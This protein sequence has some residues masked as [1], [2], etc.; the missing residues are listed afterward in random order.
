MSLETIQS[1][2]NKTYAD[3][4][5]FI[6]NMPSALNNLAK[7]H[8]LENIR[9]GIN[10]E[11]IKWNLISASIPSI[12]IKAET[13]PFA[14]GNAYVSSHTKTPY[15]P[16]TIKFKV[17]NKYSNYLTVYEWINLIY[18]ESEGHYDALDLSN[19]KSG[20]QSYATNVSIVATDEYDNPILQWIFSRAFPTQLSNFELN[21]QSTEELVCTATFVFSQ[22]KIRNVQAGGLN[23][24]VS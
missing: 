17:D 8:N 12:N 5:Y 14:G 18:D 1:P 11:S 24:N 3:K 4:F 23:A 15:D 2:L 7:K 6:M 10:K 16:L 22:M 21:Y 20:L 13:H 9:N 19:G